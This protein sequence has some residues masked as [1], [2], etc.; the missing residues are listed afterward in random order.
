MNEA[1]EDAYILCFRSTI[2]LSNNNNVVVVE[3]C[4]LP[5]STERYRYVREQC[6]YVRNLILA[7]SAKPSASNKFRV[8]DIIGERVFFTS[9]Q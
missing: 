9:K 2:A 5:Y 1:V 4:Y 6:L 8:V 3:N 7:G